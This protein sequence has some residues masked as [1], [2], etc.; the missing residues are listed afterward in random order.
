VP[1]TGTDIVAVNPERG[2][3]SIEGYY[4]EVFAVSDFARYQPQTL[5][6]N[7]DKGHA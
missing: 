2:P 5:M 3:L 6:P 7:D 4:D 1:A